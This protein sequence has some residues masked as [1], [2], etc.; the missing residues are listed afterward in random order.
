MTP[1]IGILSLDTRFP[2]ILGD[3]GNPDSY[4]LPA[5]VHVV[6]GADSTRIVIDGRP[7]PELVAAFRQ[8]ALDLAGQGAC[9]ITS[10]CGFLISVQREIAADV[11]VPV[12]LSGLTLLPFVRQ[13]S[14]QRPVGVLTASADDL[15]PAAIRA[16]GV[17]PADVRIGGLQDSELFVQTFLSSKEV[18]NATFDKDEMEAE[19]CHAA[20]ALKMRHPE[21]GSL[22]LECGNLPPY[23]DAIRKRVGCPVLSILDGARMLL[24]R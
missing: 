13:I 19:V 20:G 14:G 11:P 4:H 7:A 2:R 12:L 3:A 8:A 16:A 21:I 15:G 9:L 23:A 10:T 18:Q 24:F 6:E 17:E 22:V 1:F 5:R